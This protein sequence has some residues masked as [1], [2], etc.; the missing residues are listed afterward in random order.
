VADDDNG[1]DN[2]TDDTNGESKSVEGDSGTKQ[3]HDLFETDEWTVGSFD[4]RRDI[5]A[6]M[7][8]EEGY[9]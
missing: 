8:V 3:P 2:G 6:D 5:F 4:V 1:E 9:M 7:R